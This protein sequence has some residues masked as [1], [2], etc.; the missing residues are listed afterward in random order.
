MAC[1]Y[2]Y[3]D[4]WLSEEEVLKVLSE[5][6]E[7]KSLYQNLLKEL[8]T[9]RGKDVLDRVKRDYVR[10]F[11]TFNYESLQQE[12]KEDI[13]YNW[14]YDWR[15][16]FENEDENED[17]RE[18]QYPSNAEK[19]A[20]FNKY[21]ED[22][23]FSGEYTL[24]EQQEEAIVEL[25]SLMVADKL[26]KVKDKNLISL[27]KQLLKEMKQ[28][29]R[30]LLSQREI[31]VENLPDDMTINDLSDLLAY[32]NNKLILPNY[33]V[34]YTTPDNNKFKTYS[35]ASK[36]ISDLAKSVE[37]VD[38]D[39]VKLGNTEGLDYNNF[40][41]DGYNY[42]IDN[43]KFYLKTNSTQ[44]KVENPNGSYNIANTLEEAEQIKT[45]N[46]AIGLD[47][48]IKIIEDIHEV[49]ES[50]YKKYYNRFESNELKQ[51]IEKNKEYE[52]SKEII[53][54]WKKVNNIQYNPEEIY[55]RRQEFSSVVGAYSSFDVNLMMQNLLQHIEDNE[56]AGGK[57]AISAFTKPIYKQI[58]HLEG[59]GGKIKFKIY[60]KSEDILWASNKDAY[61]GSV[62]DAAEKVNKDK[63]SELLGVSY[64]K[65]PNLDNITTVQPNL[66]AIVD[67]LA[68]RHNELGIVLTGNNFRLEY[69]ED[70]P[71]ETKKIINGINSILDQKYGKLVK[72]A[73]KNNLLII[74]E[75]E[76]N[77]AL[78]SGIEKTRDDGYSYIEYN[79]FEYHYPE[80]PDF[81]YSKNKIG[82]FNAKE[83][84]RPSQ[85]K[86][87]LKESI[88]QVKVKLSIHEVIADS[89]SLNGDDYE[90]LNEDAG[91][92]Y[93]K[94][95][96][97]ISRDEYLK[98][99]KEKFISKN[100]EY[101]KQALINTKI[102]ALKE[103]AKKYPRILIRNEVK[104]IDI[105][106]Y[107]NKTF[108]QKIVGKSKPLSQNNLLPTLT[109]IAMQQVGKNSANFATKVVNFNRN[110]YLLS[111]ETVT[112][113]KSEIPN[114]I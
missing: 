78:N 40:E 111:N 36:H 3:N 24:E 17:E 10:K 11:S 12:E 96:K 65:Y 38:L 67:N 84:I 28:F 43:N 46:K 55:S 103:V 49:S 68:D 91:T 27:L 16:S 88:V 106:S 112:N 66:A 76:Y 85:T 60:P 35:E 2:K 110:K 8:E 90:Y 44:Y 83:V 99:Q 72:P 15:A 80:P 32:S 104:Q 54:E 30:A 51:F 39:N 87:N 107:E 34:E 29:I 101:T 7:F 4:Q 77:I 25:M 9:G 61:S 71:H 48:I 63:K 47:S 92:F 26:D 5:R 31:N 95:N 13:Y 114:C 59:G 86:D 53:E 93:L 57:F 75:K 81:T 56:K 113:E 108:F 94:N 69:D 42:Y 89:F 52:Q 45:D 82:D 50:L 64:T 33:E 102:A 1:V 105:N 18:Y 14:Y 41:L 79:G 97:S 74:T 100:K 37:D 22:K 109:N 6:K 62:W 23:S 58:G 73:I 19:E 21:I 20:A 70:I 98:A